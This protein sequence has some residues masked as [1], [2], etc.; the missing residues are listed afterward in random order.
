ME[1]T[2][3]T[4]ADVEAIVADA[5]ADAATLR[6][7]KAAL[8]DGDDVEAVRLTRAFFGLKDPDADKL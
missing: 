8:Q 4:R 7:I 6:R 5:V 1:K 2:E 3:L